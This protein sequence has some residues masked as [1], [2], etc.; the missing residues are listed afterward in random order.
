MCLF[1]GWKIEV[2]SDMNWSIFLGTPR[3]SYPTLSPKVILKEIVLKKKHSAFVSFKIEKY[4]HIA[5]RGYFDTQQ[6]CFEKEDE[7]DTI[8][9]FKECLVEKIK[10]CLKKNIVIQIEQFRWNVS[11]NL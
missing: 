3:M 8:N 5:K 9:C 1:T 10:V 6:Y 7:S 4:K 11:Q 2:S